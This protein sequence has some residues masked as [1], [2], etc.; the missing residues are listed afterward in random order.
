MALEGND[1]TLREHLISKLTPVIEAYPEI[2]SVYLFGSTATGHT[3]K[4]SDVDIAVRLVTDL[5]AQERFQIR[6]ELMDRIDKLIDLAADVVLMN[7]SS[8]IMLNQIYSHGMPVFIRDNDE[9][10]NFK[11]LKQKEF[12][13]FRHYLERDFNQMRR[14]FG[15]TAHD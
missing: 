7:D 14:Y 2:L 8:L 15:A 6:L 12:F 11:L 13:D 10:E 5:S 9:E 4:D 1:I 3:R